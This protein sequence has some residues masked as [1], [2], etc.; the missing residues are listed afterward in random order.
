MIDDP[1]KPEQPLQ[2]DFFSSDA[3]VAECRRQSDQLNYFAH[4][5]CKIYGEW[6]DAIARLEE[7][8]RRQPLL[9]LLI[10]AIAAVLIAAVYAVTD[11][12]VLASTIVVIALALAYGMFERVRREEDRFDEIK[13]S[14]D[15]FST[16][17]YLA[18]VD[19]HLAV[20]E[21]AITKNTAGEW[22]FNSKFNDWRVNRL[23]SIFYRV[24]GIAVPKNVIDKICSYGA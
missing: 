24:Y 2:P 5:Y 21:D 17:L 13:R 22:V 20:L 18:G 12:A 4:S 15:R 19:L 10:T 11:S 6:L 14:K 7:E 3:K 8:R 1:K 16:T 9:L 23:N